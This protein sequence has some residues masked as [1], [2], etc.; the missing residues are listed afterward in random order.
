MPITIPKTEPTQIHVGD[1][2]QWRREDLTDTYPASVWTLTYSFDSRSPAAQISIVASA[3]VDDFAVTV[4]PATTAA[5]TISDRQRGQSGY[6]W[7][8]KVSHADGRVFTIGS[9][10]L[11]VSL[12]L[13]AQAVGG[14]DPRGWAAEALAN[15]E[16]VLVGRATSD[17]LAYSVNFASGGGTSLSK[18]PI[19][20]LRS[21]YGWLKSE[22]S[23]IK[24]N[25]QSKT[26]RV[27]FARGF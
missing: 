15:I 13:Q 20:Q 17:Q 5:Y 8:A 3:D 4:I 2:W 22:V 10:N 6:Y 18:M 16:A 25:G 1:T 24:N 7:V 21:L 14:Y 11:D 12:D 9:G 27:Q 19:D 26:V 23:A